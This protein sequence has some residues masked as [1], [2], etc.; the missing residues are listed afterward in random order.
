[1]KESWIKEIL[2]LP[3]AGLEL[4]EDCSE[5]NP[6][7]GMWEQMKKAGIVTLKGTEESGYIA[8]GLTAYGQRVR[9]E[10]LDKGH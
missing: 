10:L 9:K 5:S 1:M 2:S 8:L 4:T 7:I 3:A 6:K